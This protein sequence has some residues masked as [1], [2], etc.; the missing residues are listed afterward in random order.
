VKKWIIIVIVLAGLA[1]LGML[2][3]QRAEKVQATRAEQAK[4]IALAPVSVQA[5]SITTHDFI[6]AIEVAGEV[7]AKRSVLVFTKVSGRVEELMVGLGE[8]V[9]Q[10]QVLAR[11]EENDLGWREKQGL[12]GER[13]AEAAVRQA[14]A[15]VEVIRVEF[16][17]AKKL[18]EEKALP[19][20]D[21]VRA[22]GQ[23]NAATAGL[24]AAKAQVEVARAGAGLAKEA[25]SWTAVESPIAGV[26]TRKFT[27]L[28]ASAG[29]QPPQP[30]FEVQDQSTLQIQIDVPALAIDAVK[31]GTTLDFEVNERP[32]KTFKATVS[33]VGKSLDAQTRRLRVELAADGALVDEGVLPA[34]L[35]TVKV[36]LGERPGLVAAPRRA[37]VQLAEGPAIFIVRGNK[38]V[39]VVPDVLNGDKLFV[40]V[41]AGATVGEQV[42]VAGQDA[43]REGAE[44]KV[45]DKTASKSDPAAKTPAAAASPTVVKETTP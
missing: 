45:V 32:G 26:V 13:A 23:L 14:A 7:K 15:Q 16:N 2:I 17:R 25:R 20:G 5:E 9:E 22:Q 19:E 37:V 12:A 8:K 28:G 44:V 11:I 43:L 33:A 35:A 27:E 40:P 18:Y 34:M 30:M 21:F 41:P 24:N 39:R 42:V 1:G 6:D 29:G 10:G 31:V 3:A 36:K 38:A 4:P